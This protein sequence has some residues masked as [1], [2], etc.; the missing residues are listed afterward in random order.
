MK[1]FFQPQIVFISITVLLYSC[2][3]SNFS[4]QKYTDFTKGNG[5]VTAKESG[6]KQKPAQ[7]LIKNDNSS[8]KINLKN[9]SIEPVRPQI[10]KINLKENNQE[11]ASQV[12]PDEKEESSNRFFQYVKKRV[13]I[14][15][16]F[17][18]RNGDGGSDIN[19]IIL[20]LLCLFIP[21]L[22]I[23]LVEGVG[24]PFWLDLI[25]YIIGAS[26]FGGFY[27]A[28]GFLWLCWILAIIYAIIICF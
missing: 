17:S 28:L 15:S 20:I 18:N 4:K 8:E 26:W 5:E 14:A 24:S 13:K 12:L 7:D 19:T 3:S 16:E 21:P 25:L 11:I 22:A 1:R 27:G 9:E 6:K 10:E 2:S 23:L